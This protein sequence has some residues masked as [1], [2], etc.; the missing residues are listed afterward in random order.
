MRNTKDG[1]LQYELSLLKGGT[2]SVLGGK[3]CVITLL[4]GGKGVTWNMELQEA[5]FASILK[6]LCYMKTAVSF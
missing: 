1:D 4:V 2:A 5:G 6:I 3:S